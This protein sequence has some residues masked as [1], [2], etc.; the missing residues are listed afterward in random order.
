MFVM[1]GYDNNNNCVEFTKTNLQAH[2][3]E[4]DKRIRIESKFGD[5]LTLSKIHQDGWSLFT[6]VALC[7]GGSFK[8]LWLGL[9]KDNEPSR[10]FIMDFESNGSGILSFL[11]SVS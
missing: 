8:M 6:N 5:I 1:I 2:T 7:Y 11:M 4:I 3:V 10:F 9:T